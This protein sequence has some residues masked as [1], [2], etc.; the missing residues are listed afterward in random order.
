VKNQ[1]QGALA[2]LGERDQLQ[3]I[4]CEV[5]TGNDTQVGYTMTEFAYVGGWFS[6]RVLNAIANS[7]LAATPRTDPH[8]VTDAQW[9][10]F[11]LTASTTLGALLP[12]S[13]F[14]LTSEN[15]ASFWKQYIPAHEA[16]LKKLQPTG[17]VV[18][19]SPSACKNGKPEKKH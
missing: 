12:E 11:K 14:R 9:I 4:Y 19:F 13:G 8:G 16:E 15:Q 1:A 10:P 5:A 17:E 18:D 2:K 3:A 6:V 7:E